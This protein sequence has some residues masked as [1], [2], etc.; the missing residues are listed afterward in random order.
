MRAGPKTDQADVFSRLDL[1]LLERA[2][3]D[4]A[5]AQQRRS[6]LVRNAVRERQHVIR[7]SQQVFGVAA[8]DVEAGKFSI[9]AQVF[10]AALAEL[11][12]SA[13]RIQPGQA[14]PLTELALLHARAQRFD[15]PHHLVSRRDRQRRRMDLSLDRVQ[16]GVTGAAQ[17]DLEA[18]LSRPGFGNWYLDRS[19][20]LFFNRCRFE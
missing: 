18:H 15:H 16:V 13:G 12:L 4:D 17:A 1:S 11:A 14:D 9:G 7:L 19:N 20:R 5:S 8:V 3:A 10:L 2:V 6:L